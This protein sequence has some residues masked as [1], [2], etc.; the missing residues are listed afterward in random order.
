[1]QAK[2]KVKALLL[3]VNVLSLLHCSAALCE[4]RRGIG[5]YK[6]PAQRDEKNQMMVLLAVWTKKQKGGEAST[7]IKPKNMWLLQEGVLGRKMA[8]VRLKW[9]MGWGHSEKGW[10]VTVSIMESFPVDTE[11]MSGF[12]LEACKCSQSISEFASSSFM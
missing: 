10:R 5:C 1:M 3:P 12:T 11:G 2:V 8:P 9:C 7:L 6:Q 4:G